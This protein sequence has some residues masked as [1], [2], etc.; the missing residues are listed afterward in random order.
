MAIE[1]TVTNHGIGPKTTT[2]SIGFVH[3][4]IKVAATISCK[5]I[6][7][8]QKDKPF[9]SITTSASGSLTLSATGSKKAPKAEPNLI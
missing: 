1:G 8:N 9:D 2:A 3:S 7:T 4:K 6:N 5:P